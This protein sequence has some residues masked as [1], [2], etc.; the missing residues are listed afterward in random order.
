MQ[1][2]L[3]GLFV[4]A[5][6]I[7]SAIPAS[8]SDSI[9]AKAYLLMDAA[10]GTVLE[11]KNETERLPIA[12]TTKIM[13][14]LIA[15]EQSNVKERFCV[16][17]DTIQV[18]G[19]S[20]G[21][22]PGDEVS[23][24][25]LA[26]GM[27]IV[28]GNDAANAAAVRISGEID[29]FAQLMNE[30]AASIFMKD[31]HFVTPS[32]LH[33]DA[34]YSTAKDLALLTREAL[35]NPMFRLLCSK[36]KATLYYGNP[37]YHRTLTNH[38][39]LLS[40]Y[41]GCIGVKTGYTKTAGRCLVSAAQR[42]G[43]TLICVTLSAPNDW[44]D[45]KTLLDRGFRT[46]KPITRKADVSNVHIPVVGGTQQAV[47]VSASSALTVCL[48]DAEWRETECEIVCPPFLY[49]PI[50]EGDYIGDAVYWYHGS[51][52]GRVPL[53]AE[54]YIEYQEKPPSFFGKILQFIKAHIRIPIG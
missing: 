34:H 7:M 18:E 32:G 15:L 35:Q 37:P 24:Y 48:S 28:S 13:T 12:S 41:K 8:A 25:D 11:A 26:A 27:L 1:K 21:L 47:G 3:T 17:A 33:D 20:M 40:S 42:D 53:I 22:L 16:D 6:L 51:I 39:R 52:I 14:A 54:G 46:A 9:S 29:M 31:T 49:A 38:N 2:R 23:L 44:E 19:S 45:H 5:A 43:V 4:C 36:Q 10:T 50:Q 30:R